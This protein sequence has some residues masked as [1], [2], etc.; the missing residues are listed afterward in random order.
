LVYRHATPLPLA[1]HFSLRQASPLIR[2]I[3][4]DYAIGWS[5]L[6]LIIT[7][8]IAEPRLL[9]CFTLIDYATAFFHCRRLAYFV[10]PRLLPACLSHAAIFIRRRH[11]ATDTG[12]GLRQVISSRHAFTTTMITLSVFTATSHY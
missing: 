9:R 5:P 8:I 11:F 7:D 1:R 3:I 10:L 12:I 6:S 2:L 4:T